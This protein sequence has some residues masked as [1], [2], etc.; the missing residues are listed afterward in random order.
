[1]AKKKAAVDPRDYVALP[2]SDDPEVIHAVDLN[3]QDIYAWRKDG[4]KPVIDMDAFRLNRH[5][6]L[7]GEPGA[8]FADHVGPR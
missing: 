2:S 6:A 1:M 3:G 8:D 5:S 4:V 7:K